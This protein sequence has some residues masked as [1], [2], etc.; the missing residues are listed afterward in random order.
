MK[1]VD[2][3]PYALRSSHNRP[4]IRLQPKHRRMMRL[5]HLPAAQIHMHAT[6][7]AWI[8]ASDRPHDINTFEFLRTVLLEDRSVLY[9]IFVWTGSAIDI[10]RVCVPRCRRIWVV[11]GDLVI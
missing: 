11:I 1:L 10:A 4:L 9:R 5:K 7:Q 8:E 2:F 3:R 6:G